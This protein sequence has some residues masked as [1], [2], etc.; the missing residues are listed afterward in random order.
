MI[1]CCATCQTG[2][3][4]SKE[5]NIAF[6]KYYGLVRMHDLCEDWNGIEEE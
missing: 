5:R 1:K 3:K 2:E 6:C 4:K